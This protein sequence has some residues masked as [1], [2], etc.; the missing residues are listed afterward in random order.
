MSGA[1]PWFAALCLQGERAH[2]VAHTYPHN[3]DWIVAGM[4]GPF[5]VWSDCVAFLA[6]WR[7][8]SGGDDDLQRGRELHTY[9]SRLRRLRFTLGTGKRPRAS[10]GKRISEIKAVCVKPKKQYK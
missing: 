9:Y 6:Q 10:S 2:Y 5:D 4:V 3:G 8:S 7:C 1:G